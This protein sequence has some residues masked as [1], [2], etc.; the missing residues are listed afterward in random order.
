MRVNDSELHLTPTEFG[1]L[2]LLM[3]QPGRTFT[4]DEIIDRVLGDEFDGY[5]R[6]VDAHV[7]SLRRKLASAHGGGSKL[8]QT[9]YGTRY[10]LNLHL[11]A[12]SFHG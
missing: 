10:R 4:R 2:E 11:P 3:G 12:R 6:T 7:S 1:L 5:D 8:I 9:V